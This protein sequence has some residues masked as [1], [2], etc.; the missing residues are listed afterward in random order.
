MI[1]YSNISSI[2][3]EK[4]I[5]VIHVNPPIGD[6]ESSV[7]RQMLWSDWYFGKSV[8]TALWKMDLAGGGARDEDRGDHLEGIAILKAAEKVGL[9]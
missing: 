8:W 4:V 1:S 7:T 5:P 2:Y 9:K 6:G 3:E